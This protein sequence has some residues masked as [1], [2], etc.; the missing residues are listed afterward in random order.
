MNDEVTKIA[1]IGPKTAA[2][3]KTLNITT[4]GELAKANATDL[5]RCN[6]K[7][8]QQK[9]LAAQAHCGDTVK[10]DTPKIKDLI[11]IGK[12]EEPAQAITIDE[13]ETFTEKKY[14][15]KDHSWWEMKVLVPRPHLSDNDERV[16]DAIVYEL[17][18]EP[19][20]RVTLLCEWVVD[21]EK[22]SRNC[23][24]TYSPMLLLHFNL[25]LPYFKF[26]VSQSDFD[27]LPHKYSVE[28][29]VNE[30]NLMKRFAHC[31]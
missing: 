1:N 22:G 2:V 4:V 30:V 27:Q 23:M 12:A 14:L 6:I 11:T 13:D 19:D 17:C 16:R 15:I 24:M 28:N 10:E 18:I 25:S 7:E 3:L 5:A 20:E 31:E 9:I 8:P 29:V 26:S 21:D